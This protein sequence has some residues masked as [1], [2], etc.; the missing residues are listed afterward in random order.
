MFVDDGDR[1]RNKESSGENDKNM[2]IVIK[3]QMFFIDKFR[4]QEEVD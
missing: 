4:L 1:E 3:Q 2:N